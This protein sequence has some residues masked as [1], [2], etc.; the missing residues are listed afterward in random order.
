MVAVVALLPAEEVVAVAAVAVAV[1]GRC[2]G[3]PP[4][5]FRMTL[6]PGDSGEW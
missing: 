6:M 5:L 1:P 2:R 3:W 4:S